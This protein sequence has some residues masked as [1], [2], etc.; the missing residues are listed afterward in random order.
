M[1]WCSGLAQACGSSSSSSSRALEHWSTGA[2]GGGGLHRQGAGQAVQLAPAGTF[3][4]PWERY[5]GNLELRYLS[6]CVQAVQGAKYPASGLLVG[7]ISVWWVG[8]T[9]LNWT[10]WLSTCSGFQVLLGPCFCFHLIN[11]DPTVR[12]LFVSSTLNLL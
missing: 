3:L 6:T 11:W 7:D 2:T 12:T 4:A 1:R 5:G 10:G 8:S 9:G